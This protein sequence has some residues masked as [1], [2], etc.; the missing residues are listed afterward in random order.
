MREIIQPV[1]FRNE[2]PCGVFRLAAV[3]VPD[4]ETED[5]P[6]GVD[7][8]NITVF[9]NQRSVPDRMRAICNPPKQR[10]IEILSVGGKA[11]RAIVRDVQY[12]FSVFDADETLSR[13]F[14]SVSFKLVASIRNLSEKLTLQRLQELEKV[15]P[16]SHLL[17][18]QT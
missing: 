10:D 18:L 8:R 13:D 17:Q 6:A 3:A 16:H 15:I 12:V 4:P 5:V 7:K 1:S 11:V 14:L 9:P 2:F